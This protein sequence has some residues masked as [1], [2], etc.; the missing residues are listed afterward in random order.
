MPFVTYPDPVLQAKAASRP[1]D[2][3]LA[4]IGSR[5][6]EAAVGAKAYGLAAAHIGEAAPVIVL[7]VTPEAP[8][9]T[10]RLFF[11]PAV[12]ACADEL[13]SG[14][15]ASV[16]LPG[17]EVAVDRP[18][19][20]EIA[21][22]DETGAPHRERLEGF[23]ARCALHEIDQVEGVFFLERVSRLKREMVLKKFHK[24]QR[25]G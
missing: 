25:A 17:V 3:S 1:V 6:V 15:E 19:W 16:S 24:R 13:E 8:R 20:T 21:F 12:V 2:V 7:N 11:N 22:D 10:Y 14:A 5:L 23:V 4:A 18:V 9:A